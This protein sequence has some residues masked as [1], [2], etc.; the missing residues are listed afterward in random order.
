M[1]TFSRAALM[2]PFLVCLLYIMPL[3]VFAQDFTA[4]YLTH[5]TEYIPVTPNAATFTVYGTTPVNHATGVPQIN[6]PLFTIEE[7]GLTLPISLSY[8]ASGI[9]VDQLSGPVGLGWTLNAGGG[10]FRQ[11]ND[12][13]DE[14]GWLDSQAKGFITPNWV[15]NNPLSD[16]GTQDLL[17]FYDADDDF[18]PDDFNYHANGLS[19]SFILSENGEVLQEMESSER[20]WR[21]QDVGQSM[22]F[23]LKDGRGN[24]YY[25][26]NV[27]EANNTTATSGGSSMS[28]D[29]HVT[30]WMLDRV[31]TRNNRQIN[32]SYQSYLQNYIIQQVSSSIAYAP[33][34]PTTVLTGSLVACGCLGE[35]Q[36]GS[37]FGTELTHTSMGH[38]PVNQLVTQIESSTVRVT[39]TYADDAT[40]STWQRKLTRVTILDK[41]ANKTKY[42]DFTYG[43]YGGD[44]RLRLDQVQETGFDGT[45]RPPYR[46]YYEAGNLPPKGSKAKDHAGYYNGAHNN[47][48]LIPFSLPASTI[49]NNYYTSL[50]ANRQFNDTYLQR[51]VLNRIDY[52]TGGHTRFTYE[53]NAV[54][55][56]GQ[57]EF[58]TREIK[59]SNLIYDTT[60]TKDG[61]VYFRVPFTL[62]KDLL[63]TLGTEVHYRTASNIC[64]FDPQLPSIDC[65][66]FN[67][68]PS[69]GPLITGSGIFSPYAVI[70]AEGSDN[71]LKGDYILELLVDPADLT[72]H[73]DANIEVFISFLF[74][75]PVPFYTGGVRVSSISDHDSDGSLLTQ[76]NYSYSGLTGQALHV[77]HTIRGYGDRTVFSSENIGTDPVLIKSGHYYHSVTIDQVSPTDTLRTVEHYQPLFRNKAYGSQMVQQDLYKNS[78]QKVRSV[79]MHYQDSI[80]HSEQY[81]VLG[82]TDFCYQRFSFPPQPVDIFLGYNNPVSRNYFLRRN[83][84]TQRTLID[85]FPDDGGPFAAA[86]QIERFS[87]NDQLQLS[88]HEKDT[89]YTA[90]T[91]ADAEQENFT[92]HPNGDLYRVD[93]TYPAD[94]SSQSTI[95]NQLNNQYMTALPVSKKVYRHQ[96]LLRGQ[97]MVYDSK[98]NVTETYRY[99]KGQG[100]NTVGGY[101]PSDYERYGRYV[102]G[103]HGKPEELQRYDDLP[104]ALLWDSTGTYLLA[105]LK[106]ITRAQLAGVQLPVNLSLTTQGQ[107][108]TLF[109]NLRSAFPDAMINTY[110]HAPLLG[111]SRT[112]DARGE[113][114]HYT[115]DGL[116]RLRQIQDADLHLLETYEYHY[117]QQQP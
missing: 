100:S 24:S 14:I 96:R 91:L 113:A 98:G 117:S 42:F 57:V 11:V 46:F 88:R 22:N 116:G 37:G 114:T 18:I 103:T 51:G 105:E 59:V 3:G 68:Y 35:S 106:G 99:Q 108:L 83:L 79:K 101:L 82:D 58:R 94:H 30:G 10:V 54:P 47:S 80:T 63:G 76:K 87:Y 112:A 56:S 109:G 97:Y 61:M 31:V 81:W 107:L 29:S 27:K 36:D 92:L 65:S 26:G 48:T 9:R 13:A 104:T 8:H 52:P 49:L 50:L 17:T 6:I 85:Y 44:P 70:G 71:L 55:S 15:T 43:K 20:I 53:A 115:Y 1:F 69:Q 19:G 64:N 33:K 75:V 93:Y 40:L 38:N 60:G 74:E 90:Q 78:I 7:D 102:I 21:H 67:I 12:R 45:V 39:F 23:T 32:F 73:P 62:T 72:A 86:V 16:S 25:F 4:D 34:C 95:L 110:T 66:R 111:V 2:W 41:L 5:H 28:Y 89:R 77:P 84:L